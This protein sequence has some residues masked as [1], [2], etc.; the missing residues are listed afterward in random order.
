[1]NMIYWFCGQPAAGKTT[2][3][4][5]LIEKLGTKHVHIDGDNLRHILQNNDYTREGRERNIQS[6]LDIARFMDNKGYD[7]IISV[8]AP[9][10]EHRRALKASNQM[11]E[12]YVHTS[13]IRGREKFFVADFEIPTE[14]Y[15]DID[16]T[17]ESV[18]NCIIKILNNKSNGMG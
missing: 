16:T 10:N 4:K 1:M 14:D 12:V 7:V 13:E 11:V 2:L 9:Y 15:I 5:A 18:E 8:V 17:H 6:V 3:A